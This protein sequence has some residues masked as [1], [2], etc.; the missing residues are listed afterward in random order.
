MRLSTLGLLTVAST[1]QAPA[2]L[3]GQTV[4]QPLVTIAQ[5]HVWADSGSWTRTT[6]STW[7]VRLR[8][9]EGQEEGKASDGATISDIEINCSMRLLRVRQTSLE[10]GGVIVQTMPDSLRASDWAHPEENWLEDHI[11]R[12]VC[13]RTNKR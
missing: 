1:F 13:E 7:S 6:D 12:A 9:F 2:L 11:L 8:T 5:T 4:W 3:N 10:R